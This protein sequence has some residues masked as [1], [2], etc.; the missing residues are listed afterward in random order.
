MHELIL[1]QMLVVA[2]A[3]N[4]LLAGLFFVFSVA[5]GPA[6]HRVDDGT[7]VRAFTSI[8]T[9]I[10]NGKFLT[11][12][13]VAP[14]AAVTCAMLRLSQGGSASLPSIVAG[15]FCS[16]F[17]IGIT[18]VGNVPL[19]Q[20]LAR[21]PID[22]EHQRRTAREDFEKRWN[23]RNLARTVTSAGGLTF[24]AVASVTE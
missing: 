13:F 19:N 5:I 24:L 15:A 2:I 22:T 23:R 4:G 10:L 6:L 21:A 17:T 9:A 20:E 14:I 1:G 8:N 7:Y 16:L 11:V 18:T 12:F 3:A